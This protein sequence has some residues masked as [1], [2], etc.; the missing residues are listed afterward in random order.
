MPLHTCWWLPCFHRFCAVAGPLLLS[1]WASLYW[2]CLPGFLM[3]HSCLGRSKLDQQKHKVKE[4]MCYVMGTVEKPYLNCE[5]EDIFSFGC[6]FRLA[7]L[8]RKNP[9][10][11]VSSPHLLINVG[12][13][14]FSLEKCLS[15]GQVF[16]LPSPVNL[17]HWG[18]VSFNQKLFPI[19]WLWVR[20]QYI[21]YG[22]SHTLS[23]NST[24]WLLL[25]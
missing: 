20:D 4:C 19:P 14:H 7:F 3:S 11:F 9:Q 10:N 6:K 13:P 22:R 1:L 21:S 24:L 15:N 5:A 18:E 23:Q 8:Y 25:H 12:L 16:L 17:V 2:K